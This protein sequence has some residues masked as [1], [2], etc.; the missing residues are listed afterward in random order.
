ML[1]IS[2]Q[3][4]DAFGA[5]AEANFLIKLNRVVRETVP[6]V[7]SESEPDFTNLLRDVV[8]RARTFGLETEQSIGA[9]AITAAMLGPDFPERFAGAREILCGHEDEE[10]KAELLQCF[11]AAL[12]DTLAS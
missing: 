7:A 2:P 1:T 3:S 12:F 9:Y 10:G 8:A 4:W 5:Q 11:V 6:E